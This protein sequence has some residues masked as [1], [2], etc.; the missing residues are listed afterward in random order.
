MTQ[1]RAARQARGWSQARL[2]AALRG[3]A[4]EA[5]VRLPGEDSLKTQLSRWEN[6]HKVP[7]DFYRQLFRSIYG[8]TD[9]ELGF[10]SARVE[11]PYSQTAPRLPSTVSF[12]LIDSLAATLGQL[13]R[14]DSLAG[15]VPV[16]T[17]AADQANFVGKLTQVAAG[18]ERNDLLALATRF[19]EF[20]GWLHQDDDDLTQAMHW[21]DRAMDY[22]QELD[23]PRLISYVLMRKSN[24]LTDG[25]D[26]ALGRGLADAALRGGVH[27]T[28]RLR[29]LARRQRANAYALQGEADGCARELDLA[30]D[31]LLREPPDFEDAFLAYCGPSYVEME[32]ANCWLRLEQPAKSIPIFER[33]LKNWPLGDQPRDRGLCLAR[34]ATAY[35]IA[36]DLDAASAA[37][38]ES[39]TSLR[40]AGSG[41]VLN[42]LRQL[43]LRLAPAYD[44]PSVAAFGA[45]FVEQFGT[46]QMT[47]EE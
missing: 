10:V 30:M 40:I 15:P 47:L 22:S 32:A 1:L 28:P 35:A 16:L 2:Q 41:R 11:T 44:S 33:S 7:N 31:E 19:A 39:L 13:S 45:A 3:A 6:G 14:T 21:T 38:V 25:G 9:R 4:Q 42:Q 26:S 12:D 24:I 20:I 36:G 17:A 8:L 18:P 34:L 29:A 37:G 46:T 23:D 43:R 5:G 27:L